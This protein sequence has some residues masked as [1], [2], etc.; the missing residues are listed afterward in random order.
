LFFRIVPKGQAR[1]RTQMSAALTVVDIDV[2]I[3]TFADAGKARR[4]V[5]L[6]NLSG[7]RACPRQLPQGV[8]LERRDW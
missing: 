2:A 3:A 1:I 7:F 6:A 4:I 5:W 8:V